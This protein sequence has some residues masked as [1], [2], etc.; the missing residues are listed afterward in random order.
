MNI[1]NKYILLLTLSILQAGC[2]MI[3]PGS[4]KSG[5]NLYQSFYMG[6]EGMQYF[7][8]PLHFESGK[9][10][11]LSMDF[12]F[13]YAQRLEDSVVINFSIYNRDKVY[14]ML[15]LFTIKNSQ[16]QLNVAKAKLLYNER[17]EKGYLSRF[18]AKATQKELRELFRNADWK[19]F[20]DNQ[21]HTPS[22]KTHKKINKLNQVIFAL[23]D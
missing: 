11:R 10:G 20:I 19:I 5:K 4:V 7:I 6:K 22:H 23:F 18:S 9:S 3:K 14:K 17:R 15:D 2:L 12:T 16:Y 21:T 8:K 1:A 13:K